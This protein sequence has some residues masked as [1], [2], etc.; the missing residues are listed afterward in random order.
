MHDHANPRIGAI[1]L[2]LLVLLLGLI[3]VC[4]DI[5]WRTREPFG[6]FLAVGIASL[7]ASQ[8]FVN[9]GMTMGLM[10]VTGVTLPFVSYGGSSLLTSFLAVGLVAN[11]AMHPIPTLGDDFREM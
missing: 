6:R 10:P 1:A 8:I 3:L 4:L 9:C 5:A 7:L 11:V 2:L